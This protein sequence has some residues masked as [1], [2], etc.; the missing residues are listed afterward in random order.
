MGDGEILL[1]PMG[2]GEILLSLMEGMT[3]CHLPE[4][5]VWVCEACAECLHYIYTFLCRSS[6]FA[7]RTT[8]KIKRAVMIRKKQKKKRGGRMAS[9]PL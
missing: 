9:M 6:L 8:P 4:R 7:H 2:D 1:S 5:G 3:S